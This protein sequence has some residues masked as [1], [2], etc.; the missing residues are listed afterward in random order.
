MH[1]NKNIFATLVKADN[2]IMLGGQVT[3][4]NLYRYILVL[5]SKKELTY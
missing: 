1:E 5:F 4:G 3:L 2:K